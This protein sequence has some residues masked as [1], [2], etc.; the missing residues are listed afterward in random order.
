[1]E[2]TR[3]SKNFFKLNNWINPI[4][5]YIDG[6]ISY[7]VFLL[8]DVTVKMCKIKIKLIKHLSLWNSGFATGC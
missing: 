3:N 1:M 6:M 8:M 7:F 2:N 4:R 5:F